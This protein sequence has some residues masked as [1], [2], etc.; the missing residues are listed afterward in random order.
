MTSSTNQGLMGNYLG[1]PEDAPVD[2][3]NKST[4]RWSMRE[5]EVSHSLP[6]PA[7]ASR[8]GRSTRRIHASSIAPENAS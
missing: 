6:I 8:T 3:G 1:E 2:T 4:L 5:Y 7:T